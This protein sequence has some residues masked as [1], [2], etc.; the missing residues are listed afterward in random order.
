VRVPLIV[1]GPGVPAGETTDALAENVDLAPTFMRLAGIKPPRAVDGRAVVSLLHGNVPADWRDA[2]LIEHHH[3]E[4]PNGDPDRQTQLS[5]N[6][7]SYEALRVADGLYVEYGDGEREWYD[8]Q[9][10]PDEL[11]NRYGGLSAGER[12]A[13]HERLAALADCRGAGC[14]RAAAR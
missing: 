6:P 7:P 13:L 4:T 10:D 2:V 8:L 14:I 3:P 11:D 9:T 12:A 5:G 1:V